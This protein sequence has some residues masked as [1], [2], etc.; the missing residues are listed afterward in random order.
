MVIKMANENDIEIEC[1]YCGEIMT[2][3]YDG[4]ILKCENRMCRF[5]MPVIRIKRILKGDK[6]GR[7]KS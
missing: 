5:E 7:E 6:N 1:P 2:L 4:K 3:D